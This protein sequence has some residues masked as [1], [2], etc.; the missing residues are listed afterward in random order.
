MLGM[1]PSIESIQQSPTL[2]VTSSGFV[3]IATYLI[4]QV[5]HISDK[6]IQY[7]PVVRP[8]LPYVGHVLNL[9]RYGQH[10]LEDLW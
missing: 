10:Y 3:L 4:W 6:A 8:G 7:P 2:L 5:L 1:I 9:I